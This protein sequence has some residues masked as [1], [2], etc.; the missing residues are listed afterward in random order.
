MEEIVELNL[1]DLESILEEDMNDDLPEID[2]DLDDDKTDQK[3]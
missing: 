3:R 1:G 2:F